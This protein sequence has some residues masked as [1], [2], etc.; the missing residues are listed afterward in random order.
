MTIEELKETILALNPEE[1]KAFV[2]DLLP[3]LAK[4][5]MEDPS[6]MMQLLPVFLGI[7]KEKG[8]DLQQLVQLASL[9][10]G[11]PSAENG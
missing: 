1:K 10:G 11:A 8:I 7:L 5:A 6:F 3:H 2:L 9:M 4:D